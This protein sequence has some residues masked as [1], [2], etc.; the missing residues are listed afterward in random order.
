M[1]GG[2]RERNSYWDSVKTILIFSVV[3]GHMGTTL[4]ERVLSIIYA[5]HMPLFVFVSGF[6]T[7]KKDFGI[8]WA[9]VIRL[10][11]IFI[12]FDLAY[13][14]IDFISSNDIT[15]N[16]M[17]TPSFGLWYIV[18]L[19]YWRSFIQFMPQAILKHSAI[20]I[21]LSILL[22]LLVGF[23]PISTQLSFQRTFV[24]FPF[25]ILGYYAQT[26][27]FITRLRKV[28]K[29]VA[30]AVLVILCTIVYLFMPVFYANSTYG[31][32][33]DCLLR[34]LQLAIASLEGIAI[35]N[36]IPNNLGQFT[37]IGKYTLIIYLLHPVFIK[38]LKIV[39]SYADW[40]IGTIGGI[41]IA[42]IITVVLYSMRNMKIFRHLV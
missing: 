3:L 4:E 23:V 17:L 21:I 6:F 7:R 40:T 1:G 11:T 22:A 20:V 28:N 25:F 9:E 24:F 36:I 34:L 10:L 26:S 35:L 12:V 39:C 13:L 33:A 30:F 37:D 2:N 5:F 41:A 8:Y 32:A 15:L 19:V 14:L 29:L 18:S 38:A 42:F 31:S 16:R 27:N